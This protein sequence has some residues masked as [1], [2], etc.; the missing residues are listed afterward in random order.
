MDSDIDLYGYA[1]I[2]PR[3]KALIDGLVSFMLIFEDGQFFVKTVTTCYVPTNTNNSILSMMSQDHKDVYRN[4]MQ[5]RG[6][7]TSRSQF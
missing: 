1:Q 7:I 2:R 3:F 4:F 5:T 6:T